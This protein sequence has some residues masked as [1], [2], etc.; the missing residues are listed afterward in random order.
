MSK[1]PQA[2][3]VR[4]HTLLGDY[5]NTLA[6]KQGALRSAQVA[7]DFADVKLAQTAFKR[8]VRD[9]EFD[10]AELALV[11]FLMAKAWGK[12]LVLLPAVLIARF[13]HPYLVYNAERGP[14]APGELAGCRV[15]IRSYSVTTAAWIRG[16]LANDY[17]VDLDRIRWVSFEDA[18][19]AEHRD[20]PTVERAA[21]GKDALAMLLPGEL[22]A[23]VIGNAVP[24]DARLQPL[25]PDPAAAA[26]DW[27]KRNGAIQINHMV[28]VRASLSQSRPQAVQE[29]F[30]LLQ[31]SKQ[32]AGR[33]GAGAIDM[34]PFGVEANRR[35]LEVA[36]DYVY[37][38]RLIPRR[39]EVDELF[40]DV[41]RALGN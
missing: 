19:V 41:T 13:Q 8:V 7:F 22:D 15:G 28:V 39:F 5:P 2:E 12:P 36:I 3:P 16:I 1:M 30:R 34:N 27:H 4:L 14:L 35:N 21:A 25:I 40:D 31:E 38:Q 18:H 17:G 26:A 23:A 37:Q 33:P 10:L 11:T 29:A 9:L 20:P 24:A 6:L 32:A